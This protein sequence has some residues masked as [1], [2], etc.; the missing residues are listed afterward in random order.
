MKKLVLFI[1]FTIGMIGSIFA[2][3]VKKKVLIEGYV[4]SPAIFGGFT[5]RA[6]QTFAQ[7]GD[8]NS[9]DDYEII[10]VHG[11]CYNCSGADFDTINDGMF[12]EEY[13]KGMNSIGA[14]AFPNVSFDRFPAVSV[15]YTDDFQANYNIYKQ[16]DPDASINVI[17][18]Y[19][20]TTRE[21]NVS[22]DIQ[23][24]NS[25]QNYRL[26]LALTEHKVHRPDELEYSQWNFFSPFWPDGV[27]SGGTIQ[28]SMAAYGVEY[29]KR[30][31]RVESIYVKHPHVAREIMPSFEGDPNSLPQNTEAGETY[32]HEFETY[33]VPTDYR[34]EMMRA[35]VLL[36]SDGGLINN[37]NGAWVNGNPAS[38]RSN[39]VENDLLVYPNPARN[40]INVNHP[41]IKISSYKILNMVGE[42]VLSGNL[43]SSTINIES[44]NSGTYFIMLNEEDSNQT[45]F[46]KF[47]K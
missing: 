15:P 11:N 1:A 4:T 5:P 37:V 16:Q 31:P 33:K 29:W 21:L 43:N 8:R 14:N 36:I 6:Y 3:D 41:N 32:N 44:L 23:F 39:F 42:E 2:Q 25:T 22:A 19:D 35:V 46:K 12:H 40:S 24:V 20:P 9:F 30:T 28:D 38:V 26:A 27:N 17:T 34:P 7:F 10:I 47:I 18:N 13:A 45:Y